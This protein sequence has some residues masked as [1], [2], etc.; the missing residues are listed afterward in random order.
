VTEYQS[1][2]AAQD[3]DKASEIERTIDVKYY[4]KLAR[5]LDQIE[6]KEEAFRLSQDADHKFDLAIQLNR[7]EEAFEIAKKEK[8]SLKWKQIGDLA[9]ISGKIDLSIECLE[10]C[11]DLSGLLLIYTSLG[12]KDRLKH[13]AK[14]AED[15]TKTNIAFACYFTLCDLEKCIDILVKAKRIP[16]AA[17]FAKTYCPSKIDSLVELWKTD[18]QKSHPVASQKIANPLEYPEQFQDLEL[19]KKLEEFIY[20]Q[21]EGA[22][23]PA[24]QYVEYNELLSQDLFSSLKENPEADLSE[25]RIVPDLVEENPLLSGAGQEVEEDAE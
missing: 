18:L 4:D 1:A 9:L 8:S 13:L 7:I 2:I 11:D 22:S 12:L 6:L 23:V 3:F 25:V 15:L 10:A 20:P 16:E 17:F 14:R 5:F 24:H 21:R 19:C